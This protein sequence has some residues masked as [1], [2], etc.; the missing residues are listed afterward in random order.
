MA[1]RSVRSIA[2]LL[3]AEVAPKEICGLGPRYTLEFALG[4]FAANSKAGDP[5]VM[6]A[7]GFDPP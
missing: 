1:K 4:G 5:R 7:G 6:S 3:G 2:M